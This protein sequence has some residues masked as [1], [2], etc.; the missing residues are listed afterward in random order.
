[1][2]PWPVG[3][4]SP[5]GGVR[6]SGLCT[7]CFLLLREYMSVCFGIILRLRVHQR[8]VC[9]PFSVMVRSAPCDPGVCVVSPLLRSASCAGL[10][11]GAIPRRLYGQEPLQARDCGLSGLSSAHLLDAATL[12]AEE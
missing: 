12:I 8:C 9:V 6:G 1:M 2:R 3:Y 4:W 7:S 5:H 11:D 10:S